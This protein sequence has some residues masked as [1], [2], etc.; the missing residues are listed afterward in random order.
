[1]LSDH[2]NS[3]LWYH[4]DCFKLK[5][6][7][8]GIDPERQIYKLDELHK[9]DRETVVKH[10]QQEVDRL[11]GRPKSRASSAKKEKTKGK[12]K[13]RSKSKAKVE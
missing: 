3:K 7:F 11:N 4:L 10:I 13:G 6:L 9:K 12:S 5:P 2:F 1:M 8:K